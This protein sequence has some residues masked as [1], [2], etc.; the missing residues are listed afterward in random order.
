MRMPFWEGSERLFDLTELPV[1]QSAC[2]FVRERQQPMEWP[3]LQ[4][5]TRFQ[6][7]VSLLAKK[8]VRSYCTLPLTTAQK[9]FGA[10]GLGSS[11]P[12]AYHD[13]DLHLL[14]GVAELVALALENAMTREEKVL[15]LKIAEAGEVLGKT[16]SL[17]DADSRTIRG[18]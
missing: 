8:G 4:L 17:V 2:G 11:R 15:I 12:N 18:S 16:S 13:D 7:A 3:D 6:R 14:R 9:R 5:E 1:E 10:L